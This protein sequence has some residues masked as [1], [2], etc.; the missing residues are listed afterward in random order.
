MHIRKSVEVNISDYP[1]N[2]NIVYL[3]DVLDES[4]RE[5]G[6]KLLKKYIKVFAYSYTDM[7]GMDPN[8]VVHNI[9]TCL[10][11]KPIKKKPRRVH[12][13]KLI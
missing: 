7:L 1:M 8:V 10:D 6:T 5:K 3:G 2:P 11:V 13:E 9:V 4:K 12:L